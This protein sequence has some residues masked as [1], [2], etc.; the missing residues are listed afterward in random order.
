[1]AWGNSELPIQSLLNGKKK[2][3]TYP[4]GKMLLLVKLAWTQRC[5]IGA[6]AARSQRT[7]DDQLRCHFSSASCR[8]DTTPVSSLSSHHSHLL[9]LVV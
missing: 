3:I 4:F 8:L 1:M 6:A 9:Q 2:K 7:V 5:L